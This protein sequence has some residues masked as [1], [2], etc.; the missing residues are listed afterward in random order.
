MIQDG[1]S[2]PRQEK[3]TEMLKYTFC[4]T[5]TWWRFCVIISIV[6]IICYIITVL[7]S[8]VNDGGLDTKVFLGPVTGSW[9]ITTFEKN[10][11]EM[12][13]NFQIWRYV[14]PVFLHAG[15]SHILMNVLTCF[16]WGMILEGMVGFL[17]TAMIYVASA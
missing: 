13:E 8:V 17:H 6:E 4:P 16:I 7:V 11:S 15:F 5:I 9:L 10:P 14:T 3:F 2:P 1:R 12:K